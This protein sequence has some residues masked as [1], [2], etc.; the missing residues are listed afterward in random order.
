M[1]GVTVRPRPDIV[2][3]TTCMERPTLHRP[4]ASMTPAE[5]RCLRKYTLGMSITDLANVLGLDARDAPADPVTEPALTRSTRVREP[6]SVRTVKRWEITPG[7][8]SR[9]NSEALTRLLVYTEQVVVALA[10][11][12]GPIVTYVGDEQFEQAGMGFWPSLPASWHEA[13]AWRAAGR[14]PGAR[15]VYAE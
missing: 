4:P 10:A 13:S 1:Q 7:K 12:G 15:V 6:L 9:A 8:L 11:S 5:L 3:S 2:S 14:V